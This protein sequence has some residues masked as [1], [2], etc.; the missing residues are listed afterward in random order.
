[1]VI[2]L[3][4]LVGSLLAYAPA[5]GTQQAG[6]SARAPSVITDLQFVTILPVGSDPQAIV[7]TAGRVFASD[8]ND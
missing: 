6:V 5:A 7:A 1:M 4:V 8:H 2:V 3:S